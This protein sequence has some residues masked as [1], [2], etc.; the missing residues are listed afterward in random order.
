MESKI[1][2]VVYG[3]TD[4]STF[5]LRIIS[6]IVTGVSYSEDSPPKYE[7][8]FG[9]NKTWVVSIAES[10]EELLNLLNLTPL[11]R[12]KETHN[13]KLIYNS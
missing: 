12:V 11:S 3:I 5:G 9:K 13:L 10:K 7:I 1:N 6:G 2:K 8:T 4:S